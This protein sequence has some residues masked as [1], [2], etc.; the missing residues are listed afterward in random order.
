M[1][2]VEAVES[3]VSVVS[4]ARVRGDPSA[5]AQIIKVSDLTIKR[6]RR[7]RAGAEMR[8]H[9]Q[10]LRAQRGLTPL[11]QSRRQTRHAVDVGDAARAKVVTTVLRAPKPSERSRLK[12]SSVQPHHR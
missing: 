1:E 3:V 5:R 8:A 2:V 9:S 10:A 6:A 7:G 11:A 12:A 4:G